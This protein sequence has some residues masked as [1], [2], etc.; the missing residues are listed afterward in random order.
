[1]V[2]SRS[3]DYWRAVEEARRAPKGTRKFSTS[4]RGLT[5]SYRRA[6]NQ[7][8]PQVQD[9]LQGEF[10]RTQLLEKITRYKGKFDRAQSLLRE[11]HEDATIHL[12]GYMVEVLE[13]KI[14]S[15]GRPQRG[16]DRLAKA[17]LHDN[18]AEWGAY[19]F[20]AGIEDWLDDSPAG[21]YWERLEFG[22]AARPGGMYGRRIVGMWESPDGAYSRPSGWYRE[23][24][25]LYLRW[26]PAVGSEGFVVRNRIPEYR[27]I[28]GGVDRFKKRGDGGRAYTTYLMDEYKR[29]FAAHGVELQREKKGGPLTRSGG[30]VS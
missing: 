10:N 2:W 29:A 28:R 11:I 22:E 26:R 21:L 17:L 20:K 6:R 7:F 4:Q 27:Y 16:K 8:T 1:V 13:E 23:G 24:A 12:R 15:T 5:P 19:G 14:A 25:D 9:V 3:G 30:R 18:N